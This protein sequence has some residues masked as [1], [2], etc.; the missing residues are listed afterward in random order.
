[1]RVARRLLFRYLAAIFRT[2]RS[3][4]CYFNATVPLFFVNAVPLHGCK[5]GQWPA[6]PRMGAREGLVFITTSRWVTPLVCPAHIATW[7]RLSCP[8]DPH[9]VP[10]SPGTIAHTWA[11]SHPQVF[12]RYLF[13]HF[14][15]FYFMVSFRFNSFWFRLLFVYEFIRC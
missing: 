10:P 2:Y 9:L 13:F 6:R 1:M 5:H 11:P 3:S 7:H 14:I 8:L 15:T 12:A 4:I